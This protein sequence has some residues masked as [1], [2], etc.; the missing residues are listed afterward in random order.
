MTM[1]ASDHPHFEK[2][3][4][5]CYGALLETEH[6]LHCT[7]GNHALWVFLGMHIRVQLSNRYGTV[8]LVSMS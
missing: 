2:L 6:F 1:L 8:R 3:L 5:A 4:L 7:P